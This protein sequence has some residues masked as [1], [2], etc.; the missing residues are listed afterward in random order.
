M[1]GVAISSMVL[2]GTLIVGDS[3]EYSLEKTAELRLG[4]VGYAFYGLDRYFRSNLASELQ[5][6]I[7]IP[8][9]AVMQLDGFGSSAGGELRLNDIHVQGIDNSFLKMTPGE[10]IQEI[11]GK[12]EAYISEN[13]ADRLQLKIDDSFLLRVEKVSLIPKNAPF[14]SEAEDQISMRL[15]VTKILGQEMLGRFNLKTSQTAPFNVFVSLDYLNDRMET[16]GKT[17]RL[18]IADNPQIKDDQILSA[19][20]KRWTIED[21]GIEI[22]LANDEQDW[23]I[24]SNRVFID[25]VVIDAVTKV[26]KKPSLI[27]TYLA[28]SIENNERSTPYSFVSAGPFCG[29]NV[30][31][32]NEI[33]INTWLAEDLA[34]KVGD[35]LKLTYFVIGPLR[36]MEERSQWFIIK[37]IVSMEGIYADKLLMPTLPGLSDAG[38]C[39]SWETGIPID[40][41]KIRDKDEEY[42]NNWKGTPKAFISYTMGKSLWENR[43]G[44]CTAI[45]I[46]AE[47]YKKEDIEIGIL[48]N[49]NPENLGFSLNGVKYEGL[50]A[51]RGGVDF[52]QLFLG[53]SFF[54][55]LAGLTLLGL[56]FNINLEN[57]ISQLGTLKAIGYSD[58]LLKKIVLYESFIVALCGVVFGSLMAILYNKLIFKALNTVWVEIVRTSV[59]LENVQISA[60]L[61][62]MTISFI[63]VFATIYF[64]V[65]KKLK[66]KPVLLQRKLDP[67]WLRISSKY[68]FWTA[69]ITTI[70]SFFLLI[71]DLVYGTGLN[72]G[73]FFLAG[74]LMLLSFVL[75]VTGFL[76]T[77]KGNKT[78]LTIPDLAV[79]N[80]QRNRARSI[81]IV[82]L[83]ALG[84]FVVVSTG[85]NRKD[86]YSEA[87]NKS[88][89]TGGYLYFGETTLPVLHDLNSEETQLDYGFETPMEFIQMRKSEG[90]DASCLNLN[91]IAQPRILGIP[92]SDL[93]GRFSF[94]K[95][96]EE[97]NITENWSSL[98][99]ELSGG[100]V[101]AIADQ[102]VI[103]WG[104][105]LKV[106]D[107]L[108]YKN[109]FGVDLQ[110]KLIAGLANSIFQ[111]NILIDEDQFLKHFPSSSGIH[112][113]LVDAEV[114]DRESLESE[115]VR[116]FRNSGLDLEYTADRL[117]E[118]NSVENTYLSIFLLLGGLG[119]ILG[120]VGLGLSLVRNIQD[121]QQ[122][123]AIL[124][125]IGF[126]RKSILNLLT[127]E[128]IIL[129]GIGSFIGTITAF[130]ATVPSIFSAY[131][132]A[133]W[134]TALIII[135]LII[136]NGLAWIY[137]IG[138]YSLQKRLIMALRSE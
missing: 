6:E 38:S 55:L 72:T 103:Q 56:L 66:I 45:R 81:R 136:L 15:R 84:T 102:T 111:G 80:L 30:K 9:S 21:S 22:N 46:S 83:F 97:F 44:N 92:S 42:W 29:D 116:S 67:G 47:T 107:T 65:R 94:V 28:N 89:G 50:E 39:R 130:I 73:I 109:E 32:S 74:G 118:F 34:A 25:S 51:A 76:N 88:S 1:L 27:L 37:K 54:M 14:I 135:A 20:N 19:I 69:W 23:S 5:E 17:N 134:L 110:V 98:E 36:K 117:A 16:I 13:L 131:I 64:N 75:F 126:K 112:V 129:L 58:R 115:L 77:E 62:G 95:T 10:I 133:S 90:D 113:F 59:L 71:K 91:L 40:L 87:I 52:A 127:T 122:E 101:P 125:A 41:E 86:L 132:E 82:I 128:H 63:L 60:L 124:R 49:L 53:M 33:I 7:G 100:L 85:L 4:N 57:R 79:R 12:N 78:K 8:V 104:L 114:Q 3:V 93:N 120:T 48:N 96:S 31:S 119:M 99:Q 18:L 121:R 11:P 26:E 105:G 138:K 123:L 2:T 137:I 70:V 43:F 35:S 106:G 61:L 24:E 108:V 68:L